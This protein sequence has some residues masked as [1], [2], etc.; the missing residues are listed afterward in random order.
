MA[1]YSRGKKGKDGN[2]H[3]QPVLLRIFNRMAHLVLRN[4]KCIPINTYN[5]ICIPSTVLYFC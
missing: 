2:L 5:V 1:I 4:H 3:R